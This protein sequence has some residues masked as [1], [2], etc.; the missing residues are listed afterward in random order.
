MV[1]AGEFNQRV[2]IRRPTTTTNGAGEALTSGWADVATVWASV[3][4]TSAK[5][6]IERGQIDQTSSFVVRVR[7][8][9]ATK[10]VDSSCRL[11]FKGRTFEIGSVVNVDEA[12]HTLEIVASETR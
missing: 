11:T 7:Y 6:R 3:R 5:E 9:T 12:N 2:T 10:T 8:S 1:D 4:P